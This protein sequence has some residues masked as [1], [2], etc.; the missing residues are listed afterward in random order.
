M[1]ESA[2]DRN[3]QR[4]DLVNLLINF[5]GKVLKAQAEIDQAA[6]EEQR[7]AIFTSARGGMKV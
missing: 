1:A 7:E 6:K 5:G 2:L 4:I 3:P